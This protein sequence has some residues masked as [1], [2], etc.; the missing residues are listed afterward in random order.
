MTCPPLG[1]V[2][3]ILEKERTC[4][5]TTP[6]LKYT[7]PSDVPLEPKREVHDA[8]V[9]MG[10]KRRAASDCHLNIVCESIAS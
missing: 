5:A 10:G 9:V 2:D 8:L 6:S 4:P 1:V 3:P 7:P